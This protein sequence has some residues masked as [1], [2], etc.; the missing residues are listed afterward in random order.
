MTK[1]YKAW[2]FETTLNNWAEL[3]GVAR[4]TLL[5]RIQ[6]G[7]PLEEALTL[8]RRPY[9]GRKQ[10][11]WNGKSQSASEWA[12]E[13]GISVNGFYARLRHGDTGEM[14]FRA[15]HPGKSKTK[16]SI[17]KKTMPEAI[18]VLYIDRETG[19]PSVATKTAP[20][21]AFDKV[22]GKILILKRSDE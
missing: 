9:R 21:F 6:T 13:L 22:N 19:K 8:T 3:F 5:K 16:K 4:C 2:G 18:D 1:K 14:L 15:P 10:Y 11:T 17:L 12:E 7:M 20:N